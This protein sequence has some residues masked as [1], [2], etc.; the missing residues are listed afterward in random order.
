M[1]NK[2]KLMTLA[3]VAAS[4][5]MLLSGCGGA[6]NSSNNSNTAT[7]TEEPAA[8]F[9]SSYT[10]SL[11]MPKTDQRY[12]NQQDRDNV[13]DGGTLTLPIT[14]IGPNWNYLSTDGNTG[15]MSELWS[16]YQPNLIM[17]DTVGGAP[18]K[19][20][21]DFL[22]SMKMV[23]ENPMVIQFDINPKAKWNDGKDIDWTAFKATWEAYNGKNP[24]YNP[25]STDGFD[26]ISSVEKGDSAKQVIV[27]FSTPCYNWQGLFG[28]LVNPEAGDAKTFTSGWVKNPHNEW[29]AGPYKVESF[30]D[31]QVTFVPNEKWWGDKPKLD[32]VI[33]KQMSSTAIINAFKN[34]EIDAT[35][36]DGVTTKDNIQAVRSV[37]D[38]Q[39]RYGYSTKTRVLEYNGK[40]APLDDI[41]VRKALTQAFDV[42]TYNS[43]QFQ[44]MD[45]K[46]EQPGSELL[47][48]YQKGYENNFPEEGKYNVDNAKKTLEGAGYKLGDDGYYAKDGKT[49][50]VS[51]T[52]FGDDATQ[53]ALATAY[54]AMMKK[55]GIK[56]K[57]VNVAESKFSDTVINGNY[58]VLPMA[59]Q[60]PSAYTFISSAPQLYT[61]GGPSNFTY[62]GS[63]EVDALVSKAGEHAEYDDQAKAANEAEK[64]ALKLYGTVPVSTPGLYYGVKKGLANYGPSGFA[65][66]LPQNIGWQK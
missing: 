4:C 12:D 62:V 55:A 58:Q 47:M 15:Y 11:P 38:A 16:W 29:A 22:T 20:N 6:N 48:P 36:S 31:S 10:G 26:K 59:W 66:N 13:K 32:K 37:K 23:T 56:V 52:F 57:V 3:A 60:A 50:E 18:L 19:P 25:P 45:W 40:S 30:S 1:K 54:Q 24:D 43:I 17:A 44:G 7:V 63:D 53:K 9:D 41:N 51:F 64:A 34:G 2:S 61:N 27:K 5:A 65:T 35:G 8:G 49:L 39:L 46:A 21:P 28:T 33:Y 42:N 14:E